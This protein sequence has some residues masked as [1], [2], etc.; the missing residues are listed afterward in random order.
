VPLVREPT[1]SYLAHPAYRWRKER[2]DERT[3][4]ADLLIRS[5]KM[6]LAGHCRGL[7]RLAESSYLS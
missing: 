5:E 3:R 1:I 6:G 4:T 7:L 2:A